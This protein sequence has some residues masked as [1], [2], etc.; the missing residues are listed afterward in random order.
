MELLEL[1]IRKRR[2]PTELLRHYCTITVIEQVGTYVLVAVQREAVLVAVLLLH[3]LQ[4]IY[5]RK[6]HLVTR[7]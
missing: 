2:K 5:R 1:F 3:Q 7:G 6:K 4:R